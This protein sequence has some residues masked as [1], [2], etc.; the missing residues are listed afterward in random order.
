ML[1]HQY[2]DSFIYRFF[3]A[4]YTELLREKQKALTKAGAH[5]PA[6][7]GGKIQEI[8]EQII[9]RLEIFLRDSEE[10]A[11]KGGAY[12]QSGYKN[13][14]YIAVALTD[15]VFLNL[16]WQGQAYWDKNILESR[17]FNT[18][19]AGEKVFQ[20][21]NLFLEQNDML[22]TDVAAVYLHAL[23]LGFQGK[24]RDS[25][26]IHA[27]D[28]YMGRLYEFIYRQSPKVFT[29]DYALFTEAYAHTIEDAESQ[30]LPDP[31]RWYYF[32]LGGVFV[33]LFI[34]YVMWF[35]TTFELKTGLYELIQLGK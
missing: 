30:K 27:I 21:L 1:S 13:A 15:E 4:Y 16:N 22:R 10:Q 17:L 8:T 7:D 20:D 32:Y 24:Y 19:K 5:L 35:D 6:L 34:T 11:L 14:Q 3:S 2:Q 25:H 18:R 33:F 29:H 28:I 9:A 31:Y 23:A 26:D 12:I